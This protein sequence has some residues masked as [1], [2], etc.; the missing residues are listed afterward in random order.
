MAV[1]S[2]S[3]WV[4]ASGIRATQL[5]FIRDMRPQPAKGSLGPASAHSHV[6]CF[7]SPGPPAIH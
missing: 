6:P 7:F 1:V 4:V 2:T 5:P 3:A